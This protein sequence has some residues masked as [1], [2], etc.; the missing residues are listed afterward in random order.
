MFRFRPD[1]AVIFGQRCGS[2]AIFQQLRAH[3]AGVDERGVK[4]ECIVKGFERSPEITGVKQ[5]VAARKQLA[6]PCAGMQRV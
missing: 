5:R 2:V 3:E 6:C 4:V 1:Q